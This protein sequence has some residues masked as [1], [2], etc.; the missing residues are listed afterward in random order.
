[1]TIK[2]KQMR[3]RW[4]WRDLTII[5]EINNAAVHSSSHRPSRNVRPRWHPDPRG[6]NHGHK[7]ITNRNSRVTHGGSISTVLHTSRR[8]FASRT[9]SVGCARE[10]SRRSRR[11]PSGGKIPSQTGSMKTPPIP[12]VYSRSNLGSTTIRSYRI[13][14]RQRG[15]ESFKAFTLVPQWLVKLEW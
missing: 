14:M 7:K 12:S 6:G 13:E 11:L 3:K 8:T 9:R 1:M 5:K 4:K 2:K 15:L 10:T